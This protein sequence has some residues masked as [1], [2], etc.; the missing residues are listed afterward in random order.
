MNKTVSFARHQAVGAY[1]RWE[2]PDFGEHP[3][4]P[5]PDAEPPIAES[6]PEVALP[7]AARETAPALPSIPLPTVEEIEKI[8]EEAHR[9]GFDEG[10]EKGYAESKQKGFKEGFEAGC[11]EGRTAA[12]AE[13]RRLL[14]L[15]AQLEQSLSKLDADIAEELMSLSVEI[16]RKVIQSTL[17]VNPEALV[18]SIR[19]VLQTLPQAKAQIHLNPDDIAL[20]RKHL[21]EVLDQAEH[22]LIEDETVSRGGSRVETPGAQI[23]ATMETRWRR[24][25]ESLGQEHG[26]WIPAAAERRVKERR[27]GDTPEPAKPATPAKRRASAKAS[28][29]SSAKAAPDAPP[30]PSQ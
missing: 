2:P 8:H 7:A 11:S 3:A 15:A 4:L 22:V 9:S 24:T 1:R 21:G 26:P 25:I 20:V 19:A 14:E 17:A 13:A 10:W 29:A 6:L 5:E 12:K 23:D 18:S 16:A 27:A 28:A 30:E